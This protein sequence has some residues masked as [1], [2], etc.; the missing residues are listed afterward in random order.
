MQQK[1]IIEENHHHWHLNMML[2]ELFKWFLIFIIV[3]NIINL[4]LGGANK[5]Q[6]MY[7]DCLDACVVKPF[8]WN[9]H[10][11]IVYA[12]DRVECIRVCNSFH[13]SLTH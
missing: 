4:V 2:R 13:W 1:R 3:A 10:P 8:Y 9:Q 7:S 5:D 12:T 11:E 6:N